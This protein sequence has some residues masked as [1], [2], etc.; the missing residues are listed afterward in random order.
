MN[1]GLRMQSMVFGT[2]VL[3]LL[4]SS[5]AQGVFGQTQE[6][7]TK[8]SSKFTTL[9]LTGEPWKVGVNDAWNTWLAEYADRF[10]TVKNRKSKKERLKLTF[11][12][13]DVALASGA[14][15]LSSPPNIFPS[16][17]LTFSYKV[18]FKKGFNFVI[19]GKL[20][21]I[22]LGTYQEGYSTGKEYN[23]GQGSFRPTWHGNNN[24]KNAIVA[25]YIYGAHGSYDKAFEAQ[26]PKTK[27][28]LSGGGRAG[29]HLWLYGDS[30]LPLKSGWNR[31]ELAIKLN[32]P[33]KADG[34]VRVKI[35][36]Q[37]NKLYDVSFRDR[38]ETKIQSIAIE[39]FFG[40]SSKYHMTPGYT[41]TTKFKDIKLKPSY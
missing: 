14:R 12:K 25:P 34:K 37:V 2:L 27:A 39:C 7:C 32:T 3:F 20:P 11:A 22:Y 17:K 6:D 29:M 5:A 21:G 33:G 4:C 40:G 19:S 30:T 15:F 41:Q 35:N 23:D 26:G 9:P 13:K 1:L 10:S 28:V 38:N 16:E 24:G 18:Y 31:V 36:G 8:R